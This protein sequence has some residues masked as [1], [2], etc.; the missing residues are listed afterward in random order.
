MEKRLSLRAIILSLLGFILLWAVVTD[1]WGYS[2]RFLGFYAG[3]YLYAV[4]S[5]LIWVLPA[6]LLIVRYRDCLYIGKRELFSRPCFDRL[7]VLVLIASSAVVVLTMLVRHK[8]F[9]LN[10]EVNP[11]LET[12]K[13]MTVGCVEEIVFRGWGYNA[14]VKAIS[15]RKAA[16]ISTALFVALHWPAYFIKWFRFGTFDFAALLTQ[17]F[18]ALLWGLVFCWLLNRGKTLWNPVIAHSVYDLMSV[19]LVG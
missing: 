18:S 16:I 15:D 19:L 3:A 4:V 13:F 10:R 5:R 9:W 6:V 2:D 11:L 7:L 17:S 1:A 8:G 12:V 14:L